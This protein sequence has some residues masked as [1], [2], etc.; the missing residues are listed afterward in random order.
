MKPV[1]V[2]LLCRPS[3]GVRLALYG[4][5]RGSRLARAVEWVQQNGL[6]DVAAL[7]AEIPDGATFPAALKDGTLDPA[8]VEG[9][10][11]AIELSLLWMSPPTLPIGPVR[12]TERANKEALAAAKAKAR[13]VSAIIDVNDVSGSDDVAR[14][15]RPA[16]IAMEEGATAQFRCRRC[17]A[18]HVRK[19]RRFNKVI[20]DRILAGGGEVQFGIDL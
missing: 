9:V 10:R 3:C 14:D 11:A 5:E 4:D 15:R 17:G 18:H 16:Q 1:K 20:S 2:K 12:R 19:Q 7:R 8:T 6:P 13:G